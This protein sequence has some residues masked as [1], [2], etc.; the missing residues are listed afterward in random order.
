MEAMDGRNDVERARLVLEVVPGERRFL[1]EFGCRMHLLPSIRT[2]AERHLAAA[3]V[4]EALESWVPDL[5]F[6]KAEILGV[7]GAWI[8]L[9]LRK[10]GSWHELRLAHRF[11][12]SS[13]PFDREAEEDGME[14]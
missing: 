13:N 4:E 12:T 7:E 8:R 10:H 14:V 2:S 1:P 9:A 11:P 6:D 3:L 5:R